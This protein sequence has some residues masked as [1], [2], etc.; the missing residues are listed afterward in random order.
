M[1]VSR[2]VCFSITVNVSAWTFFLILVEH[3]IVNF[4]GA[5]HVDSLAM[6]TVL[7]PLAKINVT[8]RVGIDALTIPGLALKLANILAIVGIVDLAV[9]GQGLNFPQVFAH[10][11]IIL[12]LGPCDS[13]LLH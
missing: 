6:E 2:V 8:A 1:P 4:P 7:F 11:V 3:A 10:P 9:I 13:L 12:L 5:K